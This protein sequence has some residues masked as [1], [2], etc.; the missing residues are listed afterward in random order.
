MRTLSLLLLLLLCG[1]LLAGAQV[2]DGE[3][4]LEIN[5]VISPSLNISFPKVTTPII[6]SENEGLISRSFNSDIYISI[7]N[8]TK[9][10][11]YAILNYLD[12]TF[13]PE[14]EK[15]AVVKDIFVWEEGRLIKKKELQH[16]LPENFNTE[17]EAQQY[18]LLHNIPTQYIREMPLLNS[19][20]QIQDAK[21]NI[22]YMETPLKIHSENDL[23]FNEDGFG[24]SGDFILKTV[25][26]QIVLNQFLPLEQYLAG[27]VPNE[28]GDNAPFEALKAQTVAARTH[29]L[30]LLL[31]NKHKTDGYD[32]C[33]ST[34]CQVYKG[35]YLQNEQIWKAI[36]EC[37]YEVL[38]LNGNLAEATYHSCCGGKTDASSIIWKGKP[39]EHLNGIICID[40]AENYDLTKESEAR[41]WINEKLPTENMTTWEKG[42]LSWHKSISLKQLADNAGLNDID[43]IEIIK[44]G[45][46]GR[47]TELKLIG[48]ETVTL[49]NEYQIRQIF[50]NLLSSFFY[51]EGSYATEDGIVTIYP[52][53]E[54]NLK[55]R[56]AGHGVGMCQ[57]GALRKARE[58]FNYEEI[59]QFY[60]PGTTL[61]KDWLN[62]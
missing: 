18:A 32:L 8:P 17:E 25:K 12:T 41:E 14:E 49:N 9:T 33:N 16:F 5:L 50:G 35:K 38:C 22:Y 54:L 36:S 23:C 60:Y 19:T 44:R 7:V 46:S 20:V 1:S 45:N 43:K 31:N 30:S 11:R 28:I 61:N 6:V 55:G 29:A 15:N 34:H 48:S 40:N 62:E 24:Y 26:R 57:V 51:I 53:K 3:L 47:I 37:A 21:G 52:H 10:V 42:A 13:S 2:L 4:Y 39:V 56:G 59:L 58:G 27:V